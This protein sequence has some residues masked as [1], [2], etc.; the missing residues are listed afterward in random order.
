MCSNYNY[1]VMSISLK[2]QQTLTNGG[3]FCLRLFLS[4][5]M[6]REEA[7]GILGHHPMPGVAT[8][9]SWHFQKMLLICTEEIEKCLTVFRSF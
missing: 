6:A 4:L 1:V 5:E 8:T 9:T 7:L 2:K 3:G